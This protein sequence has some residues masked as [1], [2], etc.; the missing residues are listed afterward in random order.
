MKLLQINT[1][2]QVGSTGRIV[3][4]ISDLAVRKGWKSYVACDRNPTTDGNETIIKVGNNF[5]KYLNALSCRVL[6]N[7]GF[8]ATRNT[9]R[10]VNIINNI[11][12]DVIHIH[13]LHGYYIDADTLFKNI[14]NIPTVW[15]LHDCWSFTGHC[16]YFDSANCSKWKLQCSKC[17][18]KH[19][20]PASWIMDKS[21]KNYM[22][23]KSWSKYDNICLVPVSQWLAKLVKKSFWEGHKIKVIRNGIDLEKFKTIGKNISSKHSIPNDK[24]IILGV[25]KVWS[26]RKGLDDFVKLSQIISDEFKIVIVGVTK[27]QIQKIPQ[28]IVCI[29]NTDDI[30]DL[31]A[32]YSLSSVF[33]NPTYSDNFPTTNIESLACGTPVITYDTGGSPEAIDS[34]T[35]IVVERGNLK[36]LKKAVEKICN[37]DKKSISP[38]CR[39]RA[40]KYFDMNKTFTSYFDIY[41]DILKNHTGSTA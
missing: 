2:F 6:D 16:A 26:K 18:L 9:L 41:E 23:K 29:E 40:E 31:S 24:K 12:P 3:E 5:S 7:D 27:N 33:V 8:F 11:K 14:H 21:R 19:N 10:L 20:Y 22:T 15:T 38:L 35:G 32:L 17:P 36:A 30:S 28:K 39:E 13:N 37:I 25:A 1:V 4:N 34:D